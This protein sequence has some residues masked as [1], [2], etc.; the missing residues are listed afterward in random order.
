METNFTVSCE[1]WFDNELPLTVEFSHQIKGVKTVFFFRDIPNGARVSATLWLPA[2]DENSDYRLNVSI[3]VKDRIG[4]KVTQDFLVEVLYFQSC[5]VT[6][7][8]SSGFSGVKC[9]RTN[10]SPSGSVASNRAVLSKR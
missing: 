6:R 5:F 1:N 4:A 9:T 2:G 7:S 10:K 8:S 3:V